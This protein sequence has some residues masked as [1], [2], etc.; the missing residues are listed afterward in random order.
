M[1]IHNH[2]G[3]WI[4][5]TPS[6]EEQIEGVLSSYRAKEFSGVIIN[7]FNNRKEHNFRDI[8]I[9][10]NNIERTIEFYFDIGGL[11]DFLAIN[12]SIIKTKNNLQ[13]RIIR[14]DFDTTINMKCLYMN[15]KEY[16][17][18]N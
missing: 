6:P 17:T 11:F 10:E 2:S 9:D 8:I 18:R 4:E 16:K 1:P 5:M 3:I 13:V 12:D 14:K 7:K 15:A